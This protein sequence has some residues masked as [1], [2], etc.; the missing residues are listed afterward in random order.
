MRRRKSP[1]GHGLRQR[2]S[3]KTTEVSWVKDRGLSWNLVE[4]PR[5]ERRRFDYVDRYNLL[6]ATRFIKA[7]ALGVRL[8]KEAPIPSMNAN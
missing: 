8:L 3:S 4:A 2:F 5:Q 7:R 6:S 1:S